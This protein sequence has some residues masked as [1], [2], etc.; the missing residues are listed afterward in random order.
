MMPKNKITTD[1]PYPRRVLIRKTMIALG[2]VLLSLF[3]NVE[4]YGIE[5]LPKKGPAILAGNHAAVLEAVMM[6]AY[7]PAIVEFLGTG[8]IPFDPH[9]AFFVN[10]YG[11]IPV[12]RGNL[13]RQALNAAA[14]V[15]E[16]GGI[17]GIFPEGGIWD[18][19]QMQAQ[20]GAA[21]LSYRTQAPIIPIGFG[22]VMGG[23]QA[24]LTLKRPRLTM[25]VGELIP[26]VVAD[27]GLA[28]LRD[29][30]DRSAQEILAQIRDL[31]PQDDIQKSS[32]RFDEKFCLTVE[33]HPG[34]VDTQLDLPEHLQIEH[35][36]AYARFLFNP[37]IL[38]IFIRNLRLP[39]HPVKDVTFRSDLEPLIAAWDSI[40][41]YLEVNPGFFTY[42]FGVEE[43]L[44]V[45]NALNEL[46]LLALWAQEKNYSLTLIPIRNYRNAKTGEEHTEKG[47]LFPNSMQNNKRK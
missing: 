1:I 12:N 40:L 21:W 19:G 32:Q 45:K 24:A 29:V 11:L 30:L 31:V 23:V 8:D 9:Y 44:A 20:L 47:G 39:V 38:D 37:T 18:A 33:V 7:S 3:A 10:A 28:S 17:L 46:R 26:A 13:D 34:A 2:K 25:N 15:L 14:G 35:G 5:R 6:A 42:R 41:N 4:I 16:Q 36:S 43:G 27:P 22:G